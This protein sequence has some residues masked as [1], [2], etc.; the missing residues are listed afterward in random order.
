METKRRRLVERTAAEDELQRQQRVAREA[1]EEAARAAS[2]QVPAGS[3]DADMGRKSDD[4][5]TLGGS[6]GKDSIA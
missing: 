6:S 1:K 2:Q 5:F 3:A 4:E